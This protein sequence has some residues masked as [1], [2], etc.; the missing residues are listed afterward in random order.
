MRNLTEYKR[1]CLL[2]IHVASILPHTGPT[3]LRCNLG[4]RALLQFISITDHRRTPQAGAIAGKRYLYGRERKKPFNQGLI[5]EEDKSVL[6][7]NSR[8]V[9]RYDQRRQKA[10]VAGDLVIQQPHDIG[11]KVLGELGAAWTRPR[12]RSNSKERVCTT[13][14]LGLDFSLA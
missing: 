11:E 9:H 7:R 2:S 13:I 1:E 8:K 10:Q 3:S 6:D 4:V 14:I 12:L 5:A